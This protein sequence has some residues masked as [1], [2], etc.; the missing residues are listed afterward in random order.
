MGPLSKQLVACCRSAHDAVWCLMVL[1]CNQQWF[2]AVKSAFSQPTLWQDPAAQASR[3]FPSDSLGWLSIHGFA[4]GAIVSWC[5]S[6]Y[7]I[8][9]AGP[10]WSPKSCWGSRQM[11]CTSWYNSCRYFTVTLADVQGLLSISRGW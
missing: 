5:A 9:Y 1:G 2:S 6:W 11:F 8:C 10:A 7:H 3:H 4:N